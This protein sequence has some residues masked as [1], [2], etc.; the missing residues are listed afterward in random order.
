MLQHVI[1]PVSGRGMRS[2]GRAKWLR[3]TRI[4]RFEEALEGRC[5]SRLNQSEAALRLGVRGRTFH[6]QIERC[7][8]KGFDGLIDKRISRVSHRRAPQAP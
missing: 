8:G 1:C 5:S 4:L 6:R 7:E 2:Q 3:G